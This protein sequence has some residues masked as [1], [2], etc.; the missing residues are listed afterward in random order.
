MTRRGFPPALSLSF[1]VL[2]IIVSSL[3]LIAPAASAQQSGTAQSLA[4]PSKVDLV[5][6]TAAPSQPWQQVGAPE[7]PLSEIPLHGSKKDRGARAED[8]SLSFESPVTYGSGGSIGQGVVIA[9]VNDDGK[10]DIVVSSW[11]GSD[12]NA[13]VVGVLIGNGDGT[14]QPVV[15]YATAGVGA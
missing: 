10:P 15:T 13:G 4:N 11:Y 7:T 8:S 9:D 3:T 6:G 12:S 2:L 14:F 5:H 1:A